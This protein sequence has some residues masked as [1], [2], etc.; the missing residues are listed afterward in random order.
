MLSLYI[1]YMSMYSQFYC[2]MK[3]FDERNL[4]I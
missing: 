2:K 4:L 1:L 3:Q